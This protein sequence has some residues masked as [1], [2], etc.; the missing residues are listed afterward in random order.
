MDGLTESR[1]YALIGSDRAYQSFGGVCCFLPPSSALKM[2]TADSSE[3]MPSDYQINCEDHKL[4]SPG[5]RQ[6]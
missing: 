6:I 2:D 1:L 3:T 4:D 5:D